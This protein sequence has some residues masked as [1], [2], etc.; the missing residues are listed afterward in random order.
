M[1]DL[2]SPLTLV[3]MMI[4][5]VCFGTILVIGLTRK[6]SRRRPAPR[7]PQGGGAMLPKIAPAPTPEEPQAP[8][9]PAASAPPAASYAPPSYM[10]TS[11][12]AASPPPSS[13]GPGHAEADKSQIPPAFRTLVITA[14]L[15]S[16]VLIAMALMPVDWFSWIKNI[17]W[18]QGAGTSDSLWLE[19]L[20]EEKLPGQ[21][22][23]FGQV[24]NGGR[25]ELI[26][27]QVI[28][29]I[30]GE[31]GSLLDTA[32]VPLKEGHLPV[33]ATSEF[34]FIYVPG[35]HVISRYSVSFQRMDG[36]P[37]PHKDQRTPPTT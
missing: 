9:A 26:D 37:L 15:I 22:R 20:G 13:P 32:I 3:L 25:S 12:S 1:I 8:G 33:Q 29:K 2:F 30:Y 28:L 36:S 17:S 23:V 24:R 21:F 10:G 34:S 11:R 18:T 19:K 6:T 7:M 4:L 5:L 35:N 16:F 14:G 27:G 31:D